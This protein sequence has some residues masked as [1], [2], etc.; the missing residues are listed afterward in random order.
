MIMD[1]NSGIL[2]PFALC[3]DQGREVFVRDRYFVPHY[4]YTIS[5]YKESN[6]AN[7]LVDLRL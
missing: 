4:G 7:E 5:E 1:R 3:K 2:L 6:G